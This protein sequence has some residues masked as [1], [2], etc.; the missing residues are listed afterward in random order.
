VVTDF[1][2]DKCCGADAKAAWD[3]VHHGQG[4]WPVIAQD[5]AFEVRA[6]RC[7]TCSQAFLHILNEGISWSDAPSTWYGTALPVTAEELAAFTS[8]SMSVAEA[9]TLGATR[10]R[11]EST[12]NSGNHWEPALVTPRFR[13]V[14]WAAGEFVARREL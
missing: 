9:G 11:L 4:A 3:H 8:G 5:Y 12:E 2:C 10:S 13:E 7:P 14:T 1:G 6:T